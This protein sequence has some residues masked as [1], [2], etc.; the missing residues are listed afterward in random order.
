M[1]DE[2]A[3]QDTVSSSVKYLTA[4]LEMKEKRRAYG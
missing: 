3:V 1:E 2:S 4:K